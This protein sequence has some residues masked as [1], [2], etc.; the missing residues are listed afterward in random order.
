MEVPNPQAVS[1]QA[2]PASRPGS[3][4]AAQSRSRPTAV[5]TQTRQQPKSRS[6]GSVNTAQS[7]GLGALDENDLFAGAAPVNHQQN[8]LANHVIGDPG[9]A[10][11]TPEEV[12]YRRQLE[13][14][15]LRS[16]KPKLEDYLQDEDAPIRP[17]KP[18]SSGGN[19]YASPSQGAPASPAAP[20]PTGFK[21]FIPALVSV[22]VFFLFALVSVIGSIFSPIVALIGLIIMIGLFVVVSV[23]GEIWGMVICHRYHRDKFIWYFLFPIYRIGYT[24]QNFNIMKGPFSMIV[25]S[26]VGILLLA[27]TFAIATAITGGITE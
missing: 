9:F 7:F 6:A 12:A 15:Q 16:H 5:P 14:D 11:I 27:G 17:D 8:P 1:A 25:A 24:F 23:G 18:R 10:A 4:P 20:P 19:P 13:F 22:G 2:K 26:F 21:P 3:A